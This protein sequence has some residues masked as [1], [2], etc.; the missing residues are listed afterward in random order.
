LEQSGVTGIVERAVAPSGR[1]ANVIEF[2][3]ALAK[4]Y[5]SPPA[6]KRPIPRRLVVLLILAAVVLLAVGILAAIILL[7]VLLGR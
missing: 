5:S 3:R 7:P 4:V 1:Y 6:E 2:T